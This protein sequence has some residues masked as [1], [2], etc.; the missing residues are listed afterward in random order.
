ML[1]GN[2]RGLV[3]YN[4]TGPTL[5]RV[6]GNGAQISNNLIGGLWCE[7]TCN[8]DLSGNQTSGIHVRA[9]AGVT[10]S[11]VGNTFIANTQSAYAQG[12]YVLNTAP[13]G[14]AS[15][16]VSGGAGANFRVVSG[17]LRLAQ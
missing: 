17:A 2:T 11:A 5:A 15:C 6:V 16:N 10:V 7:A 1:S 3:L 8:I 14:A 9:N 4:N 13:C 12:Q